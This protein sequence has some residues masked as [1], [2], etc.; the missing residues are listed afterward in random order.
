MGSHAR[1]RWIDDAGRWRAVVGAALVF[2]CHEST[3]PPR[4]EALVVVD[5][6]APIPTFVNRLRVDFF[7]GQGN[8]IDSRDTPLRN[9]ADW[10]ASFSVFTDDTTTSTA[11][12]F[13][14]R[15]RAYQDG[16]LRDYLGERFISRNP[17]GALA[18]PATPSPPEGMLPR[19]LRHDVDATPKEEPQPYLAIDRLVRVN[20]Q[21]GVRG[22]VVV[23]LRGACF[24]TMADLAH[25][26][27]C[28]D[29]DATLVPLASSQLNPDMTIPS[30]IKRDF[31][32]TQDCP[33]DATPR[34]GRTV[35]GVPLYDQ[36]VCVPGGAFVMGNDSV[37]GG[38]IERAAPMR[39]HRLSPFF[40]DRYEVTVGQW[41]D[42]LAHGFKAP[43]SAVT[44]GGNILRD[45]CSSQTA[46]SEGWCSW[47]PAPTGHEDLAL[48]CVSKAGAQAF[49]QWRGGDLPTEAQWEY[50]ARVAGRP[51]PTDFPWG[52]DPPTCVSDFLG[53][54]Y[55]H[56]VYGRVSN[57]SYGTE[58]RESCVFADPNHCPYHMPQKGPY[59]FMCGETTQEDPRQGPQGVAAV[60]YPLPDDGGAPRGDQ[61]LKL[62][63]INLV[64]GVSEYVRDALDSYESNCWAAAAQLDPECD[65]PN[66]KTLVRGASW[67]T[68]A[69]QL[70]P[71]MRHAF[72]LVSADYGP[73]QVGFRCA[74]PVA[75]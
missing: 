72:N 65:D 9:G 31:G 50:V 5:T 38:P 13:T 45:S 29:T 28:V 49:C 51:Q 64:G 34:P 74:R 71:P 17:D 69:A 22:K 12:S 46:V 15:L 40:L 61:S 35:K 60:E 63:V 58:G 43:A 7:D 32:A 10:P 3:L 18:D 62:Q 14:L 70:L 36:D 48:T 67:A 26:Q 66:G 56:C 53:S 30:A 25:E 21:Y 23:V 24:G 8:W 20:L 42:A 39:I 57:C 75:P 1:V 33:D 6:D 2:T 19:L 44:A 11:H 59:D 37:V 55:D 54:L 16:K 41:R 68:N 52:N 27:T 73:P 47:T 4:G